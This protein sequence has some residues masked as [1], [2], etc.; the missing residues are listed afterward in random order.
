MDFKRIYITGNDIIK[1]AR[2]RRR[3]LYR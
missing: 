2:E 3:L 1:L